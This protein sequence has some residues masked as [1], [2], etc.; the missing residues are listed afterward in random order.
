MTIRESG[1][2]DHR[3]LKPVVDH[4]P[5]TFELTLI[6]TFSRQNG[7][8]S[9][10]PSPASSWESG[11]SCLLFVVNR[12]FIVKGACGSDGM[13]LQYRIWPTLVHWHAP[14]IP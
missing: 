13:H 3:A 9:K 10:K 14:Y 6:P 2:G 1:D 8:R 5:K 11:C 12:Q 7:R 4:T